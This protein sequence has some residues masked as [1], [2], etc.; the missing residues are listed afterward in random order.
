MERNLWDQINKNRCE[1]EKLRIRMM[2][3]KS[4]VEEPKH[5]PLTLGPPDSWDGWRWDGL[6]WVREPTKEIEGP[7]FMKGQPDMTVLD[8]PPS[9]KEPEKEDN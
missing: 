3:K 2:H 6:R 4:P 8:I 9:A 1:I 7:S 5:I